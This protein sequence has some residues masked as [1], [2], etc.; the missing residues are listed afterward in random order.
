MRLTRILAVIGTALLL[1]GCL[2]V[3]TKTPIGTTVGSKA[4]PLLYGV[5]RGAP[6]KKGDA[7]AFMV[8][9]K[10]NDGSTTA[11]LASSS[12][13]K[14]G[15]WQEFLVKPVALGDHTFLN[16]RE[17]RVNGQV[18]DDE[19]AGEQ[20]PLLYVVKNNSL[21][22]IL[23]DE[24]KTAEAIKAGLIAGT[25]EPGDYGDVHITADAAT[26]DNFFQTPAGLALFSGQPIIMKRVD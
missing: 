11:I 22:L 5:W 18:A 21:K 15:D 14:E 16:V 6:E 23:L 4:D 24:K 7:P 3:T 8:F 19:L 12:D 20:I 25:I 9:A 26:L 2:P 17:V 13:S 10:N 1:C